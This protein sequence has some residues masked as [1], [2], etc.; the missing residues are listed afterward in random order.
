MKIKLQGF[1]NF[2]NM[3]FSTKDFINGSIEEWLLKN[4]HKH[5][6]GTML[7]GIILM[8]LVIRISKWYGLGF[9]TYAASIFL[10]TFFGWFVNRVVE[11]LQD[12]RSF[13][14]DGIRIFDWGDIRWGTYGCFIGSLLSLWLTLKYFG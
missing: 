11:E 14:V 2:V 4:R 8:H 3:F 9:G 6:F 7:I 13:K 12:L 10:I 5:F 1:K